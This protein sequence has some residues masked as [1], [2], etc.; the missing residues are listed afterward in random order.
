MNV[1][2][3]QATTLGLFL[4]AGSMIVGLVASGWLLIILVEL[5]LRHEWSA[6]VAIPRK[7][8]IFPAAPDWLTDAER[9]LWTVAVLISIAVAALASVWGT[10]VWRS[11]VVSKY[12][13]MTNEEV[14]EFLKRGG[15]GPGY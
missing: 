13:W 4:I 12:N 9:T 15:D 8:W 14:D 6:I 3:L 11:L 1:K 7:F 10:R 2:R 5:V